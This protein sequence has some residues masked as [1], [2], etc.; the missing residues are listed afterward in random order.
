MEFNQED[1]TIFAEIIENGK[2]L[3]AIL[4]EKG[5]QEASSLPEFKALLLSWSRD[6]MRFMETHFDKNS[7]SFRQFAKSYIFASNGIERYLTDCVAIM[8]SCYKMPYSKITSNTPS[9][10]RSININV[11]QHQTQSQ[12][13]E[14]QLKLEILVEAMTDVLNGKQTKELKQIIEEDISEEQKKTKFV[15]KL[16]SFGSDTLSNILANIVTNPAAWATL[17][18]LI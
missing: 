3:V 1:I 6:S 4:K 15:D 18:S 10:D 16:K 8:E 7:I 13:Q 9:S 17:T 12:N 14:Q 2:Q 5:K 11:E